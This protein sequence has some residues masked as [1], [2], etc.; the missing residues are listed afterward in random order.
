MLRAAST[1]RSA[2]SRPISGGAGSARRWPRR[3]ARAGMPCLDAGR[4]RLPGPRWRSSQTPTAPTD[5]RLCIQIQARTGASA[6]CGDRDPS[7]RQA[8]ED[9]IAARP[10]CARQPAWRS[11][12]ADPA[13]PE[14][15][16]AAAELIDEASQAQRSPIAS[17]AGLTPPS[18]PNIAVQLRAS[19]P[20]CCNVWLGAR[21][22][23]GGRGLDAY[24]ASALGVC[25]GND[26]TCARPAGLAVGRA[27][28]DSDSAPAGAGRVRQGVEAAGLAGR[29]AEGNVRA[30]SEAEGLR[31]TGTRGL[32]ERWASSSDCAPDGPDADGVLVLIE[33]KVDVDSAL[34]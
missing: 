16:R 14:V 19:A 30:P 32:W 2:A 1:W 10:P 22:D 20:V 15:G 12:V 34:R 17:H 11:G 23:Q 28:V 13:P 4:G 31:S 7:S 26:A 25:L 5:R 8:R 29:R 27:A 24:P 18:A 21:R 3:L 9:V 6:V 33:D